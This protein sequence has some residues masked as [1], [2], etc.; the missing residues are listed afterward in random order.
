VSLNK[1][2]HYRVQ[3]DHLSLGYIFWLI[4]IF[5]VYSY[6]DL[7]GHLCILQHQQSSSPLASNFCSYAM[8]FMWPWRWW[9]SGLRSGDFGDQFYRSL[10]PIIRSGYWWLKCYIICLFKCGGTPSCCCRHMCNCVSRGI[11]SNSQG[12]SFCKNL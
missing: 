1:S 12:G 5:N 6:Q 3:N 8:A 2:L 4:L 11:S 9:Y 7:Q 10:W